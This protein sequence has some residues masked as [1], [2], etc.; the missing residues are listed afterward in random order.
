M[1]NKFHTFQIMRV[2]FFFK[3]DTLHF[4]TFESHKNTRNIYGFG[5]AAQMAKNLPAVQETRVRS[6]GWEDPLEEETA[7]HP[8]FLPGESYGQLC[9]QHFVTQ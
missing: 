5:Q 8:V 2:F 4:F 7:T 6:L 3:E 9:V 1:E